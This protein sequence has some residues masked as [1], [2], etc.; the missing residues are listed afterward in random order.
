MAF[1]F[2]SLSLGIMAGPANLWFAGESYWDNIRDS[3]GDQYA[4]QLAKFM[5]TWMLPVGTILIL[6]GALLG[7][8]LGRKM[9]NKHFKKAGIA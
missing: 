4:E 6:L 7:A 5:P 9:M 8:I 3:M 1:S 2:M